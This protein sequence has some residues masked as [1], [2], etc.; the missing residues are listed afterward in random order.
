MLLLPFF[1]LEK[2]QGKQEQR[3]T[4]SE[5]CGC[6]LNLALRRAGKVF[7][8]D[9]CWKEPGVGFIGEGN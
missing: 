9:I 5:T 6:D 7:Q 4:D 3:Q 1:P 2:P 8:V